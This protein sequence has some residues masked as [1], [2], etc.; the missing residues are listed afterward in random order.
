MEKKHGESKNKQLGICTFSDLPVNVVSKIFVLSQNPRAA[1]I[2]R[3]MHYGSHQS[4]TI[5]DFILRYDFCQTT[6]SFEKREY[7]CLSAIIQL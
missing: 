1:L 6:D 2:T 4:S 7:V 5:R 3:G